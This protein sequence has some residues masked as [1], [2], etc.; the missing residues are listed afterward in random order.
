MVLCPRS[1]DNLRRSG[2]LEDSKD[3]IRLFPTNEAM[4]F[5]RYTGPSCSESEEV[6]DKGLNTTTLEMRR[7]ILDGFGIPGGLGIDLRRSEGRVQNGVPSFRTLNW[8][9][10]KS[11]QYRPMKEE[12]ANLDAFL[13]H[14]TFA[15]QLRSIQG[16][17]I[18]RD[19]EQAAAFQVS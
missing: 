12:Y 1:I 17:Q 11:F 10:G 16:Y 8:T 6:S 4:K 19:R 7:P 5:D 15:D 3:A 18:H 14:Q 9:C 13:E 2:V